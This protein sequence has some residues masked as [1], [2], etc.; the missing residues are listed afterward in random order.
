M[1]A[2][3]CPWLACAHS[4]FIGYGFDPMA[5]GYGVLAQAV[6]VLVTQH[7]RGIVPCLPLY[8][9]DFSHNVAD[10]RQASL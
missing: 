7:E 10:E 8:N 2:T 9:V 5:G 3:A 1:S 4:S 6:S